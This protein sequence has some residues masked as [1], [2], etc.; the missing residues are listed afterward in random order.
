MSGKLGVGLYG[1]AGHQIQQALI[2]HPTARPVALSAFEPATPPEAFSAL[3]VKTLPDLDAMLADPEVELISF[4]S[5][6]KDE[7]GEQVIRALEAG[8]H[9][10]AEKPCC[11]DEGVLDR[12][13]ETAARTGR[14]FHEMGAGVLAPPYNAMAE[15]IA[16]GVLG[17]ILQVFAQK[18]YPWSDW[19]PR[20]E[21]ID[22]GLSLQVGV[23]VARFAE[24]V[25]GLRIATMELKETTLGNRG[26]GDSC[27]RAAS[28]LMTF[29]N[30]AVGSGI[31]NYACPPSPGWAKWG[32]ETLRV[33]GEKGF[34]ESIDGGRVVTLAVEGR[35]PFALPPSPPPPDQLDAIVREIRE[36]IPANPF[37]PEA[38]VSPTRWVIRAKQQAL[39]VKDKEEMI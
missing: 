17:E 5:P 8:K 35:Q 30:G 21:R 34:V 18:S 24:Q 33:F 3:G 14:V 16:S 39:A 37:T 25:A 4:C 29:A 31:A 12:I 9:V 22:G 32:Y 11:M 15:V 26:A 7:Q 20:E 6:Y 27:R 2:D 13:L 38:R 36:G 28:F 1:S 10:L 23:Y 19:R